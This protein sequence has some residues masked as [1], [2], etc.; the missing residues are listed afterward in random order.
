MFEIEIEGKKKKVEVS[1]LTSVLY[2][3]EFGTDLVKDFFGKQVLKD[4]KE[5][6]E[7][8]T[9]D[10]T[11]T[12]WNVTMKVL[13]AALKTADAK[14]PGYQQWCRKTKGVNMWFAAEALSF[15]CADCFF[16]SEAAGKAPEGE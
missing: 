16:R 3:A 5:E 13:W 7:D 4:G 11:Q 9:I 14:V 10:F 2:E 6:S 1:F 15:E 8:I 12:N